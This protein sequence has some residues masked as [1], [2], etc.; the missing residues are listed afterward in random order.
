[1]YCKW[2]TGNILQD[3]VIQM[4]IFILQYN[5]NS[6][7]ICNAVKL[8]IAYFSITIEHS[9][10]IIKKMMLNIVLIFYGRKKHVSAILNIRGMTRQIER[11]EIL[12]I[13]KDI[14][15]SDSLTQLSRDRALFADVPVTSEVHCLNMGLSRIAL[16]AS[17]F[18]YSLRGRQRRRTPVRE[19]HDDML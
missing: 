7:S 4:I 14:E 1:M 13:V 3:L 18:L 16:T 15:N 5:R 10:Q 11:Q 9:K 19:N 6:G 12:N 2:T 17:S 8:I